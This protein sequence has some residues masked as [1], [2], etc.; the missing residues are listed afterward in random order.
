MTLPEFYRDYLLQHQSVG[1]RW[2]HFIG[3]TGMIVVVFAVIAT[4]DPLYLLLLPVVGYGFAWI[5]HFFIE[6][7][8]P[9]TF[10]HPVKSFLCDLLMYR[11]IIF[12][13]VSLTKGDPVD[14]PMNYEDK[15]PAQ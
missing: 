15:E 3:T 13:R 9:A 10:E 14:Q 4:M 8:K 1:N 12:G 11:D 7:N 6:K 2:L 5:G